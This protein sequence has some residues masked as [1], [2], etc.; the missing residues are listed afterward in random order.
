MDF[1]TLSNGTKVEWEEFSKW[2][3]YKQYQ[4]ML[5]NNKGK[6]RPQSDEARKKRADKM[7]MKKINGE[8]NNVKGADHP[9]ARKVKTPDGEFETLGAA[10]KYYSVSGARIR[11]WIKR[12]KQGFEFITP[13]LTRQSTRPKTILTGSEHKS[14]RAVVTPLGTFGSL[15]EAAQALGIPSRSLIQKI[16]KCENEEY[17]YLTERD[18][19]NV[20][21]GTT[22][23]AKKVM[24]PDGLFES[25]VAS[26]RYYKFGVSKMRSLIKSDQH[27]DFYFYK[28]ELSEFGKS[29]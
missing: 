25:L 4:S 2:S 16:K 29:N 21:R 10:G 15:K 19:R 1:V 18:P 5:P 6:K 20:Y 9:Q 12:N 26:C 14:S 28:S 7:R 22:A 17:K 3:A 8:L 27:P 11:E 23:I 13:P 24:T